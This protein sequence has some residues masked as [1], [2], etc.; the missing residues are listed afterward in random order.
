VRV[1]KGFDYVPVTVEEKVSGDP[2]EV[3][4]ALERWNNLSEEGWHAADAHLH[5]DRVEPDG[6]RDWFHAMNAD[7]LTHAQFM[8]LK[9]GMVPGIWAR[10]F[11]Y[12]KRG[13]GADGERLIVAGEEYRD[14]LQ[15]HILL[16]GLGEIIQPIMAGTRESP[17]NYPTFFDVLQRARR[18]GGIAGPAHGANY[19]H[20]PT[21]VADA[22]L[23]VLDF[24]E[25]GN[26]HLWALENWYRL[27]NCGFILPPSAG[28]DL[29]NNPYRDAWQ[30][31]L[32]S[33]RMYVKVGN[34]RSSEAWNAA[35]KGGEV[36]ATSG[37]IIRFSVNRVGPGGIV[38]L[39]DGG[40]EVEIEA[41]LSGPRALRSLEIVHGGRTID[42]APLNASAG[43]ESIRKLVVR[44]K[45]RVDRS[46]WL[47]ARGV[48]AS[49]EAIRQDAVAHTAAVQVLVG[50]RPIRSPEDAETFIA[51]FSEQ[52]E[53]YR[54]KGTYAREEHRQEALKL[55]DKAIAILRA[56][57]SNP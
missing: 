41:E 2:F 36:F 10:Q 31:F 26:A 33:M 51:R 32:G 1:S 29:P 52:K 13:E 37:P 7:G 54:K 21:G 5:Y 39:P 38:N 42:A 6:D 28:T 19:G 8:V 16:F 48:G 22:I 47:A 57:A 25:I 34:R 12:G 53:F 45:L 55:F 43:E 24:W 17:N 49:I 40:G 11:A 46:S 50:G 44:R 35:V 9:G 20:S 15:G 30:P 27:M 14:R 18:S 4:V 56:Q 23:G 3:E